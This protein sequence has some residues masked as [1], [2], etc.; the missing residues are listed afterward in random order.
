MAKSRARIGRCCPAGAAALALSLLPN[1]ALAAEPGVA[2]HDHGLLPVDTTLTLADVVTRTVENDPGYAELRARQLQSDAWRDRGGSWIAG[3]PLIALRYQTDRWDDD[4]GLREIES[5]IQFVLWKWGERRSARDLGRSYQAET[6]AASPALRW[7][8]AG[9]VRRLLWE[10]AE[11]EAELEIAEQSAVVAARVAASVQRRH[12]LGDV[13]RRDVLLARSAELAT[14]ADVAEARV[15]LV[16]AERTYRTVTGLDRRPVIEVERLASSE[17][18]DVGHPALLAATAA[19]ERSEAEQAL[20]RETGT[21]SPTV[22]IGPR[23][24][25]S[26]GMQD[27]E[28]SIGVYLTVPFGGGSHI[29]TRVAAAGREVA[30]ARARQRATLRELELAMHEAAHS[31]TAARDNLG[32]ATE[33]AE[34]A[35]QGYAM[36]EVAYSRGEIGLVE[37][38]N[39]NAVY[40]DATRQTVRFRMEVNRQTALYNQAVGV[41]P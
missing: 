3:Q 20:A 37:L 16:D 34:L 6:E 28:D 7:E 40:L 13:A 29:R 15:A 35:R 9:F 11:T 22:T 21:A 39:L 30:V 36:G 33:R 8:I 38:L 41:T 23:R 27:Y 2:D 24:E 26:T 4:V 17:T 31:L 19:V 10:I 5:G 1:A 18:I 25:R 12:E 32:L 14:V